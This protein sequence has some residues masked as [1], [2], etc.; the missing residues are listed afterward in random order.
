MVAYHYPPEGSSSGVQRTLTFS[1]YLREFGWDPIALTAHPRAYSVTRS[2]QLSEVP[3]GLVVRRAFALDS[4]RHLVVAG[5]TRASRRSPIGGLAGGWGVLHRG[6][7]LHA[8]SGR[9][10]SGRRT[11]LRLR[12]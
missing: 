6:G 9:V 4:G 1:R 10:S 11:R 7:A 2:D 5:R 8:S 3:D 12:I